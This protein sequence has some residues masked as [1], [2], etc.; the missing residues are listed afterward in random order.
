[1]LNSGMHDFKPATWLARIHFINHLIRFNNVLMAVIAEKQGGKSTFIRVLQ[2][3][4]DPCV[5]SCVF[6]ADAAFSAAAFFTQVIN[7]FD[8]QK[9][10]ALH[11]DNLIEQ[12]NAEGVHRLVIIDDAQHVPL[13]FIQ[14]ALQ[15]IK[16]HQGTNYFHLCLVG[17]F[18]LAGVLNQLEKLDFTD[19]IHT[20]EPGSLSEIESRTYLL[21]RRQHAQQGNKHLS[22]AQI[23]SFHFVTKGQI[24]DINAQMDQYFRASFLDKASGSWT[25]M[26]FGLAATALLSLMSAWYVWQG[27]AMQDSA[28]QVL[29]QDPTDSS[30]SPIVAYVSQIAP[31]A[32]QAIR[33]TNVLQ[34][35][36]VMVKSGSAP[37][38]R[39]NSPLTGEKIAV[40][41]SAFL[42]HKTFAQ[43]PSS[44]VTLPLSAKAAHKSTDTLTGYT[45]QLLAS[46][47][48]AAI[49]QFLRMHDLWGKAQILRNRN[50]L[51]VATLGEYT[52]VSQ[53]RE[54]ANQLPAELTQL[55]PWVRA[56]TELVG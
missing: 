52:H 33:S 51:Y 21:A 4:L 45:I 32:E 43:L 28:I 8:L 17:D 20:M 56:R 23:Q 38:V 15:H 26:A 1:M 10:N 27:Q 5:K 34:S 41:P 19:L 35:N 14:V 50:A 46:K 37:K 53:A 18:A 55:N 13:P 11:W 24:S 49:E 47:D 48:K 39:E 44:L 12:I 6:M 9:A 7:A 40:I 3:E 36:L 16:N 42:Q 30:N 31:L 54:V 29:A 2:A 22:P 25:K